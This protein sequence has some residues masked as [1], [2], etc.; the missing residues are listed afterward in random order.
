VRRTLELNP[1]QAKQPTLFGTYRNHAFFTTDK[2]VM[3][4]I[5]ADKTHRAHAIIE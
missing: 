1:K 5:A 3:G 2:T 4:T